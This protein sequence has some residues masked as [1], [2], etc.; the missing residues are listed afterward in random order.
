MFFGKLSDC[1]CPYLTS[2]MIIVLINVMLSEVFEGRLEFPHNVKTFTRKYSI[3]RENYYLVA[4][5]VINI[6]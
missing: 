3:F 4:L 1:F 2:E 6:Y 5:Q